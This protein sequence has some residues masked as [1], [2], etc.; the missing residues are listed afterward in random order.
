MYPQ[1]NEHGVYDAEY[2]IPIRLSKKKGPA[3]LATIGVCQ[4][5]LNQW[6]TGL[7]VR[8]GESGFGSPIKADNHSWSWDMAVRKALLQ[9][10]ERISSP[11]TKQADDAISLMNEFSNSL[12]VLRIDDFKTTQEAKTMAKAK[13]EPKTQ[14][15]NESTFK[16]QKIYLLARNSE[17]LIMPMDYSLPLTDMAKNA[18]MNAID[19]GFVIKEIKEAE[20]QALVTATEAE[21]KGWPAPSDADLAAIKKLVDYEPPHRLERS[22]SEYFET[23]FTPSDY[24]QLSSEFTQ[25]SSEKERITNNLKAYTQA[26][27]AKLTELEST[28][29][30]VSEELSQG[31]RTESVRCLW[32]MNDPK[33]N[34]KSL[35]RLD[36]E[37]RE[38]V[39]TAP[40]LPSDKQLTLDD[41][42]AQNAVKERTVDEKPVTTVEN[43][44]YEEDVLTDDEVAKETG[45]E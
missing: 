22:L 5:G 27:K 20:H 30:R 10:K 9:I 13:S 26:Q 23:E 29:K 44:P 33:R 19:D 38:L 31:R 41:L 39:K 4:I 32:V 35:Y 8:F 25:A 17:G 34:I 11:W 42:A 37:P 18:I 14:T 21:K 3:Y 24:K 12:L 6:A 15:N 7:D 40:M 1:P 45:E 36:R 16:L 2:E 28:I 43:E